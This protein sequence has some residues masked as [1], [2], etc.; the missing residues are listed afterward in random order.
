MEPLLSSM[1]GFGLATTAGSRAGVVM[2]GL[3]LFHHTGHFTL[4]PQFSWVASPVVMSVLAVLA[5]AEVWADTHPEIGELVDLAALLPK[6][7]VGFIAFAAT[8]GEVDESLLELIGSGVLGSVA[9]G[10]THLFRNKLRTAVR[11]LSE[12]TTGHLN[13]VYSHTETGSAV[14][15]VATSFFAPMLVL[16]MVVFLGGM[17]IWT[18]QI[19]TNRKKRCIYEN[20]DEMLHIKATRC[21][22]CQREQL[23]S[24][25]QQARDEAQE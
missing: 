4:A 11:E 25:A 15:L 21:P 24:M 18:M 16:V 17:G 12:Y 9:A 3:G 10:T 22:T 14:T 6:V 20:C 7:V 2:L 19:V 23:H 13:S 1:M 8:T 5:L